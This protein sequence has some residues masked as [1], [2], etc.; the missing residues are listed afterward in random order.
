MTAP[1]SALADELTEVLLRSDP[2]WAS[3]TAISGYDDAVPDLSPEYQQALR[4]RLVDIIVR[5]GQCEAGRAD[6]RDRVL[7]E[8]RTPDIGS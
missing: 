3:F 4:R 2:F 7:L 8:T 1:I 6:F 5:S